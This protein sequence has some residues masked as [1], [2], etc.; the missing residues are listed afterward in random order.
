MH[1][2]RQRSPLVK[3]LVVAG[4]GAATTCSY[5]QFNNQGNAN[6]N[7]SSTTYPSATQMGTAMYNVDPETRQVIVVT[8]EETAAYVKQVVETLDRPTPQVLIK[9]VFLEATYS[10]DSDIG[11]EGIYA[12]NISGSSI[13]QFNGAASAAT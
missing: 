6:Q 1:L 12:H 8:D 2:F 10:K 11:I 3:L 5:A 9:C 7:R 13:N 4:L